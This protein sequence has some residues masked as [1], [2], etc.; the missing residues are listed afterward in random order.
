M[1]KIWLKHY[2]QGVPYEINPDRYPSITAIFDLSCQHYAKKIAYTNLGENLNYQKL[3]R[4]AT[5]F[6]SFLQ[7]HCG[8]TKGDRVGIMMPN[9]LQYPIC[10]FG[11]DFLSATGSGIG[12]DRRP[13]L[14]A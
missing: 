2:Q 8:I 5:H 4:Y 9:S 6:A 7:T 13:L 12:F 14:V 1:D 3:H 11:A 10:M